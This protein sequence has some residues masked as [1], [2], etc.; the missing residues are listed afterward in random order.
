MKRRGCC[1]RAMSMKKNGYRYYGLE[2]SAQ[3]DVIQI[4]QSIGLSLQEIG[5]LFASRNAEELIE[6][7]NRQESRINEQ[8]ESLH[9]AKKTIADMRESCAQTLHKPPCGTFSVEYLPQRRLLYFDLESYGYE[10]FENVQQDGFINWELALRKVKTRMVELG[11]PMHL[12]MHAGCICDRK[13]L[14]AEEFSVTGAVFHV[15]D[16]YEQEHC[17]FYHTPAGLWLTCYCDG[18]RDGTGSFQREAEYYFAMLE[19][20][21]KRGYT[22]AGDYYGDVIADTPIFG[23]GARDNFMRLQIPILLPEGSESAEA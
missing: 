15:P 4:L 18:N 14:E 1:F 20:I 9:L 17:E 5:E 23:Y 7:M 8:I 2:Q 3:L 22:I 13:H 16:G 21:R 10:G 12:F 19:E 6:A 11:I